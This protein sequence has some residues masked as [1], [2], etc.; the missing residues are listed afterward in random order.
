MDGKLHK[1]IMYKLNVFFP[2]STTGSISLCL[3]YKESSIRGY[4]KAQL[5]KNGLENTRFFKPLFFQLDV[6]TFT[7]HF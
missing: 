3:K 7:C 2:Q 1:Y 4:Y 5:V 6:I